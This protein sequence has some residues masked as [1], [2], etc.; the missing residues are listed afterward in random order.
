MIFLTLALFFLSCK[1]KEEADLVILN[2]DIA[3]LDPGNPQTEAIA[4]RGDRIWKTGKNEFIQSLIG[5]HTRVID[6]KGA[7]VM[8][9]FIE[10][11]GHFHSMGEGRLNVELSDTRN[12]DEIVARVAERVK[13]AKPGEWILG[14]GWHQEKWNHPPDRQVQ[15]FPYHDALSAISP[16]NPVILEHASG[17]AFIAN[18]KA[19]QLAGITPE[20]RSPAGGEIVKDASGKLTGVFEEEAM[21]GINQTYTQWLQRLPPAETKA[22]WIQ[23]VQLAAKE[24]ISKGITS[25]QDAGSSLE[26]VG[27]YRKLAEAGQLDLRLWVM[28]YAPYDTIYNRLTG[29]PLIDA[30]NHFL[31]VRAIKSYVDGAL[32]SYGAWLL[33][34]YN[35][36]PGHMGQN[37]TPLTELEKMAGL[38]QK[39]G[40]QFCVHAIGDRAN[41]E[42]LD[43][44]EKSFQGKSLPSNL[45]W[46]IEH[47]QHIDTSDIPR[48]AKLGVIASM[49]G[50]HC[51]S[52][53]P[54]VIKRLGESRAKNGA[55]AWRSL[56][57]H[58]AHMANGTDVPVEDVDPIPC[59]YALVTRKRADTGLAFFPEQCMTREEALKAY[60]LWNAY[61]AFE[62]KEKGSLTTGK[63]ADITILD[64]NLL[65]CRESDI[66]KTKVKYTIVGGKIK[67]Q[68]KAQ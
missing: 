36:K 4:I 45:R 23:S 31:T 42:M 25:F 68:N 1:T 30:G 43:L 57:Q 51:T 52:D 10:G 19:M 41:R 2:G 32:G 65:T 63:L 8:P 17:H 16:D 9:G 35:D 48:F 21:N 26:E 22:R 12:W 11:H 40:M 46:R 15:G 20:T 60:T 7:F 29:F 44:F 67:F 66:L 55:Y 33:Q 62:E 38:C 28:I 13:K 50:I 56:L 6:A 27:D 59:F 3:T 37:T 14:R 24:C 53:A 64:K 49:Q 5:P 58:G 54:F 47:A 18:A 39:Q 34:P 61:A